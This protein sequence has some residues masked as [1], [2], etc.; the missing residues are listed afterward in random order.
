MAPRLTEESA[1]KTPGKAEGRRCR[2]RTSDRKESIDC[3]TES[4]NDTKTQIELDELLLRNERDV[5]DRRL[6][7]MTALWEAIT[8]AVVRSEFH[9]V[10]E[11]VQDTEGGAGFSLSWAATGAMSQAPIG[12]GDAS[13]L[14]PYQSCLDALSSM[15]D[16]DAQLSVTPS[17]GG[18]CA[19]QD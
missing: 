16:D 1:K 13:E 10:V 11:L 6:H 14:N 18:G 9:K 19:T 3:R 2:L 15:W 7:K 5:L 17:N 12:L 4:L 8:Q